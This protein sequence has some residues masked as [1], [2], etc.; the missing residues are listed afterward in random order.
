M[1]L[2]RTECP[3]C[4]RDVAVS[5]RGLLWRHDGPTRD[6]E[7]RSCPGSLKAVQ[8]P[9][10]NALLLFISPDVADAEPVVMPVPVR[11]F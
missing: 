5:V 10:G 1:R 3:E 8:A 11:L 2:P 4:H 9:A 6:P 7:L